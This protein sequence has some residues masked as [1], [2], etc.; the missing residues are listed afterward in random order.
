MR[1]SPNQIASALREWQAGQKLTRREAASRLHVEERTFHGWLTGR[2]VGKG[3]ALKLAHELGVGSLSQFKDMYDKT[4]A[5]VSVHKNLLAESE[6]VFISHFHGAKEVREV[7][8]MLPD[9]PRIEDRYRSELNRI[10]YDRLLVRDIRILRI[11]QISNLQRTID[12]IS[13]IRR[14]G[15]LNYQVRAIPYRAWFPSLV[16][17]VFDRRTAISG[18]SHKGVPIDAWFT[19]Y[20]GED[21]AAFY[22]KIWTQTWAAEGEELSI[23]ERSVQDERFLY[24]IRLIPGHEEIEMVDIDRL[25]LEREKLIEEFPPRY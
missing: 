4:T 21:Y 9:Y 19:D 5:R 22:E 10:V 8:V 15:G 12:V 6:A 13:M 2:P 3:Y 20:V 7:R 18:I 23:L 17:T 24:Y 14:F 16:F 25:V 11:E 1:N